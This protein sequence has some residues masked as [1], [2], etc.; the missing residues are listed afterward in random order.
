MSKTLWLWKVGLASLGAA[1]CQQVPNHRA[2]DVYWWCDKPRPS[3]VRTQPG[4][5]NRVSGGWD[6]AVLLWERR[7]W[8]RE[9]QWQLTVKRS[10]PAWCSPTALTLYCYSRC[11]QLSLLLSHLLNISLWLLCEAGHWPPKAFWLSAL[12]CE[13]LFYCVK[14]FLVA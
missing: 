9:W 4:S 3:G 8:A 14:P 12:C 6:K 5:H 11:R 10:Q 13:Q 2:R 1:R 7:G